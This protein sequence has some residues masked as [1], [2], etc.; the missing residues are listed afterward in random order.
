MYSDLNTAKRECVLLNSGGGVCGGITG[1]SSG[2]YSL[3]LGSS[4]RQSSRGEFSYLKP[5]D[6]CEGNECNCTYLLGHATIYAISI[7]RVF[8]FSIKLPT[9]FCD[10]LSYLARYIWL[11]KRKNIIKRINQTRHRSSKIEIET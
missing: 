7:V 1:Q 3:R 4:F 8:Q 11:V 10:S 9:I 6:P 5:H 2:G